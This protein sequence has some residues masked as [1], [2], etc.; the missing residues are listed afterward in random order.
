MSNKKE[1]KFSLPNKKVTIKHIPRKTP[2]APDASPTHV[3]YGGMLSGAST[4][5]SAPLQRNGDVKNVLT[6]EEKEVLEEMTGLKLS[7][8]GDFWDNFYVTLRRDDASNVLDLS[9]PTDYIQYKILCAYSG[10]SIAPSWADRNRILSYKFAITEPEE[11]T[12][13]TNK[14]YNL[15]KEAF[16]IYGRIENTRD[17]LISV[18]RL[19][20]NKNVSDKTSIDRIQ[21]KVLD[22]VDNDSAKFLSVVNDAKFE[23]KALLMEAVNQ[24]IIKRTGNKYVT[25]DGL[26][27]CESGEVPLF[28]NAVN[29][30]DSNKNQDVRS[31]IE[32]KVLKSKK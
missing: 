27:L 21:E 6:N 5:Y 10:T 32:A 30:L 19:L 8:Y 1:E 23:T 14:R 25:V 31:L 29:Y 4:K 24:G 12:I 11:L 17:T 7:I 15:K 9:N 3:A 22:Y 13:D 18:L 26:E 28:T 20:E 16:K 2:L